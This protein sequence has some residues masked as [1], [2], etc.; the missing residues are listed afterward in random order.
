MADPLDICLVSPFALAGAH[1][2]AE[3]VRGV[4]T[5]LAG[6]GHRVTVL[7]PSASSQAL[8]SGRRRLRALAGG[9]REALLALPGE[10]LV[11]AVAPAVPLG[12]R[13]RG[14][15]AGLP[16]AAGANVALAVGDGGFDIVHAH[17][18]L[19][20]GLSLSALKH[21][22]ALTV[23]T[24]HARAERA[25]VYP[26]RGSRRERYAAR[27]DALLATSPAAAS[28]AA[29]LYPGEYRVVP[30]GIDAVFRP[31]D[32]PGSRIVIEWTAESR[33]VVRALIRL[34]ARSPGLQL[35]LMWNRRGRRPLRPYVPAQARGRVHTVSADAAAARA[36]LLRA[37][38]VFVTARD[39]DS[40]LAWEARACGCAV[41]APS[42][43]PG[44]TY[45]TDQ[46]P[47]AAAAAARLLDD[48]AL[49]ARIVD[50]GLSAVAGQSMRA[51]APQLEEI[52][53]ELLSRRRPARRTHPADRPL[54]NVDLHMHTSHSHDCTTGVEELLDH[55]VAEGFGA[56]A[57]TDHNEVSGA[58]EA[59]AMGKPITVI[60]GEEVKTSQGEVIG[61]FLRQKIERGLSMADTIGEIQRQGGLVLM[62]HPFDR[63]HT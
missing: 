4:A 6:R 24:F 50:E 8:R 18:P 37:A 61:L 58:L 9:D 7:A 41:V 1:P 14:R 59:A 49:R 43:G 27:I 12:Q 46:P 26:L 55:C 22:R 36:E 53:R 57:I 54:I 51:V 28:A 5:E 32:K 45:A 21:T 42:G 44:L 47:L 13:G 62:P 48:D 39:D 23:A 56:I 40:R 30:A 52:Y 16:V 20:P 34:A 33:S 11:V 2:V 35:T 60:V 17:D 3:H 10:P 63:M 29:A 31:A 38:S 19:G 25:L 15:G